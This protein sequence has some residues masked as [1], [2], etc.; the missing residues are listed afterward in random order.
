[1]TFRE[2]LSTVGR[3]KYA[4]FTGRA[5]RSE[6]WWWYLSVVIAE[7]I[8]GAALMSNGTNALNTVIQIIITVGFFIPTLAVGVRRLHDTNRSG[9]NILWQLIPLVGFI[10]VLVFLVQDSDAGD[11]SFGPPPV[12]S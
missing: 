5:S 3:K 2:S 9:W 8:A 10:I 1:M 7:A 6:F 11:N 12:Q 4:T